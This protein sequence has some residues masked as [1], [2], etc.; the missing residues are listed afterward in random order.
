LFDFHLKAI[1]HVDLTAPLV[2]GAS[3]AAAAQDQN[4]PRVA[5]AIST[6]GKKREGKQG[7]KREGKQGKRVGRRG[8]KVKL[9]DV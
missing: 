2:D 5:K 3:K 9:V 4:Q 1:G 7:K 6:Y 8:K